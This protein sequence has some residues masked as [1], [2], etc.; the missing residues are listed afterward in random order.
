MLKS[1]ADL[2]WDRL[3]CSLEGVHMR[4]MTDP[5]KLADGRTWLGLLR[6]RECPNFRVFTDYI[7]EATLK[8]HYTYGELGITESEV[9]DLAILHAGNAA[10]RGYPSDM[11]VK[12]HFV[13]EQQRVQGAHRLPAYALLVVDN[14]A[15]EEL[16]KAA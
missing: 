15:P 6:E 16:P 1:A 8:G 7:R 14:D 10:A 11:A 13:C 5:Q 4:S 9:L 3:F 2:K 12:N